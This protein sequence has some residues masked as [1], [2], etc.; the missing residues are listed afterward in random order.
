MLSE[1]KKCE[2]IIQRLEAI[3]KNLKSKGRDV[4][5][6]INKNKLPLSIKDEIISN[7]AHIL[8]GNKEYDAEK[9]LLHLSKEL[10]RK[11]KLHLCKPILRKVS[12]LI[13][14]FL[15]F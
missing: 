8:D 6:W 12:L 5:L 13:L 11:I 7:M 1:T 10:R 9:P 15:F 14:V 4:E 3:I 2:K